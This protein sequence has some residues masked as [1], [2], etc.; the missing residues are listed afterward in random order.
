[1]SQPIPIVNPGP[2]SA[3]LD[4]F[5]DYV[6][7]FDS[8]HQLSPSSSSIFSNSQL[9]FPNSSQFAALKASHSGS[10]Q[11]F[12]L[13]LKDDWQ[14]HQDNPFKEHFLK[15]LQHSENT[16]ASSSDDKLTINQNND[17]LKR[18][19][20]IETFFH[21]KDP[22][23]FGSDKASGSVESSNAENSSMNM[24]KKK[25]LF[26][27]VASGNS[28]RGHTTSVDQPESSDQWSDVGKSP[29]SSASALS[30]GT[31]QQLDEERFNGEGVMFHGKLIGHEYVPEARGEQ[32]CQQALKKLKVSCIYKC[33]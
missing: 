20:P 13:S 7:S 6:A 21:W 10:F 16:S 14:F 29:K 9:G 5:E 17:A 26:S 30:S 18:S 1:M 23:S 27:R 2:N 25:G 33:L 24:V 19:I 28:H 32:M 31:D 11:D 4:P 15:N 3:A 8:D 22:D 12:Q